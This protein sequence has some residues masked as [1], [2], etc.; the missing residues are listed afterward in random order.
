MRVELKKW[1]IQVVSIEPHLFQTNLIAANAQ[2][3]HLR[4][5][6]DTSREVTRRDLGPDYFEGAIRLLDH[7]LGTA[8]T[9]IDAVV[10][11]MYEAVTIQYPE[12]HYWICASTWERIYTWMMIYIIPVSVQ[13]YLMHRIVLYITG[14]PPGH[15]N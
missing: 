8:R 6:W 5:I 7:G 13:D 10:D 11:T 9:N 1:N 4:K 3:D 2:R 15:V 12:T 14:S